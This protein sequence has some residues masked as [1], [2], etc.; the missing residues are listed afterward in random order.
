MESK[1]SSLANTPRHSAIDLPTAGVATPV[2][3]CISKKRRYGIL[4]VLILSVFIDGASVIPTPS[5]SFGIALIGGTVVCSSA[6]FVFTGEISR[7]LNIVTQQQSWVV[8]SFSPR[9]TTGKA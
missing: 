5:L 1:K 9:R 8:V 2:I 3:A 4:G 6:F 7:D